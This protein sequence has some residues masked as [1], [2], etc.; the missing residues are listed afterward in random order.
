MKRKDLENIILEAYTEVLSEVNRKEVRNTIQWKNLEPKVQKHFTNTIS[1][2]GKSAP[3][4]PKHDFVGSDF[5]TFRAGD[6]FFLIIF[7]TMQ[8]LLKFFIN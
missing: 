4:D 7:I 6:E 3:G 8:I 5:E 1:F 2:K